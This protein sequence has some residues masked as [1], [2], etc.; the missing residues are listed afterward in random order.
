MLIL[1][2][3]IVCVFRERFTGAAMRE[4]RQVIVTPS[5]V[6]YNT[7]IK[8]TRLHNRIEGP[9]GKAAALPAPGILRGSCGSL[10]HK[11][12]FSQKFIAG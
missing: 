8:T 3:A 7:N 12:Q 1:R 11:N 4:S 10:F 2:I 9:S 5:I 6:E